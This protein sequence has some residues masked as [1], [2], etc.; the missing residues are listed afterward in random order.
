MCN[1]YSMTKSQAAIRAFTRAM[2]D[3]TGNLPSLPGIFPDYG[4]PIVRN[5]ANGRE[6]MLAR[7]GMPSPIFALEGKEDRSWR[8]QHP[9]REISPLAAMAR[10]VKIGA[11]FPSPASQRTS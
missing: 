6:L 8:H 3:L 7:W 10:A 1:L 11:W 4:A 9:Q 2:N 5:H